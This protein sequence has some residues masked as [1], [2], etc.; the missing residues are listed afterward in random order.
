MKIAGENGEFFLR[1]GVFGRGGIESRRGGVWFA[2][3]L[4]SGRFRVSGTFLFVG[5]GLG[6]ESGGETE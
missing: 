2:T 5:S 1:G 4:A 3:R 6:G